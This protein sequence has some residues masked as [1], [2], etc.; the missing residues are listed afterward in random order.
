MF[1]RNLLPIIVLA[2]VASMTA[3]S[4]SPSQKDGV[5]TITVPTPVV[6][7]PALTGGA[8]GASPS[9]T[10]VVSTTVYTFQLVP[11]G[12]APPYTVSWKFGDGAEGAGNTAVHV[13]PSTG[14]FVVVATVMDS[15]ATSVTTSMPVSIRSVTGR[16]TADL[17]AAG[18]D[19]D[20]IVL[21]QNG[22]A[23]TGTINSTNDFGLGIGDGAA[24]NPRAL[25]VTIKFDNPPGTPPAHDPAAITYRGNLDDS[26]LTWTGTV[27]GYSGCPCPFTATRPSTT[28]AAGSQD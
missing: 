28:A 23:V 25:T 16:W 10:G 19:A 7:T 12:G 11:S 6:V 24:S 5:V 9:G 1:V 17:S 22:S 15:K 26:L 27:S 20:R 14:D 8:I 2:A 3:C 4:D 21:I 18:K 13:Y